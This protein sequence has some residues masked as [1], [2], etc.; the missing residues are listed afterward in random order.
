MNQSN[1]ACTDIVADED[2]L[3]AK[4]VDLVERNPQARGRRTHLNP[5][6]AVSTGVKIEDELFLLMPRS[7]VAH[8]AFRLCRIAGATSKM[9]PTA[10]GRFVSLEQASATAEAHVK[11]G[12]VRPSRR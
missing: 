4:D 11:L 5:R 10:T 6:A 1:V 7:K 8:D 2:S 12:E 9:S 3:I